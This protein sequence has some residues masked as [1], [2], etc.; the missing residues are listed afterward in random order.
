MDPHSQYCS[1]SITVAETHI[2]SLKFKKLIIP[3]CGDTFLK[4]YD[5]L[6]TKASLLGIFCGANASREVNISST[7][8]N[9]YVMSNSGSFGYRRNPRIHFSFVA[10]YSAD[11][12]IS[13]SLV[14]N[15]TTTTTSIVSTL[16]TAEVK[17]CTRESSSRTIIIIATSVG[18]GEL[19][20]IVLLLVK[21]KRWQQRLKM[22]TPIDVPLTTV[23]TSPEI[24]S[25]YQEP[26]CATV[27]GD[28]RDLSLTNPNTSAEGQGQVAVPLSGNTRTFKYK[29]PNYEYEEPIR[30]PQYPIYTA[31]DNTKRKNSDED[32]YQKLLKHNSG[33]VKPAD[34]RQKPAYKDVKP[35]GNLPG[36]TELDQMKKETA[37][38]L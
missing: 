6:N 14:S 11:K 19:F 25:I 8:N 26:S 5:G 20:I 9:V 1:W 27:A 37:K 10:E 32:N 28:Y 24:L 16:P 34:K 3:F 30:S 18:A 35:G 13:H 29:T 21:L 17:D 31:L 36:Y 7:T 15:R 38:S 12:K 22:L 33:Y 4:I 23:E 2:V